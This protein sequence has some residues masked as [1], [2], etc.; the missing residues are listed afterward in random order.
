MTESLESRFLAA[1]ALFESDP[2]FPPDNLRAT[3]ARLY[4][5]ALRHTADDE[6]RPWLRANAWGLLY[7]VDDAGP[8][9][10]HF[11]RLGDAAI[12]ELVALLDDTRRLVYAGSKDAT[13]G[14][15][16]GYRIKDAAA[17]YLGRILGGGV[18][19]HQVLGERDA[20]IERLRRR[21]SARRPVAGNPH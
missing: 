15:E 4:A 6:Q 12:P 2:D 11:V 20:E 5:D 18:P 1:E 21:V 3:L 10:S 17:F 16:R 19:F 8:A 7:A 14:N 13:V 9:G